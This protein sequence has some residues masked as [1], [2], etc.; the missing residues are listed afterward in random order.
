MSGGHPEKQQVFRNIFT[1]VQTSLIR[2]AVPN[3]CAV[4][5][6]AHLFIKNEGRRRKQEWGKESK[7]GDREREIKWKE[8][9]ERGREAAPVFLKDFLWWFSSEQKSFNLCV[10]L[11]VSVTILFIY[12]LCHWATADTTPPPLVSHSP[13]VSSLHVLVIL[14]T[15]NVPCVSR[16]DSFV[17]HQKCDLCTPRRMCNIFRLNKNQTAKQPWPDSLCAKP[18]ALYNF[19]QH[20]PSFS[21]ASALHLTRSLSECESA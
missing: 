14:I 20:A 12:V 10:S 6:F 15:F 5:L 13:H 7:V 11:S 3:S 18:K 19:V 2:S 21:S 4:R 1:S 8:G 9:K 17:N 16:R